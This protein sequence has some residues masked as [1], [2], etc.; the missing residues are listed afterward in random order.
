MTRYLAKLAPAFKDATKIL[1]T[2]ISAGGFGAAANYPQTARA[3]APVPV[4]SLDDSGPPM[5]DPYVTKCLQQKW[6]DTWGFD[7]TVLADCGSDCPDPTNYT[8][9]AT[10]HTAKQYPNIPFGLV[11]DTDDMIITLFYAV[12]HDELHGGLR[13]ARSGPPSPAGLP[14]RARAKL[15][16]AA[17]VTNAAGFIFQG[18]GPY[19]AARL[20]ELRHGDGRR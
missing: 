13:A 14:R 11:E 7:K 4:Y 6:A 20:D 2:G 15:A 12:R 16:C 19:V 3:F 5:E 17:G 10:I 1:L 9:D 8:L 18:H